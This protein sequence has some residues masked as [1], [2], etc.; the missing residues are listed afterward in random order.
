MGVDLGT[1]RIGVA[2]CDPDQRLAT[3][4]TV[5]VREGDPAADRRALVRLAA[6]EE[7]VGV[8]VG[9]PLSLDGSVGP[10]A[11]GALDEVAQ[12]ARALPGTAVDT[13]DE[14]FTTVAA[15]QALGGAAGGRR[16]RVAARQQVD[17]VAAAILLQS[18][19]DQRAAARSA[20]R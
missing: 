10:A 8:V 15:Y 5:L 6:E 9:L 13:V 20:E 12:L 7:V 3:S 2:L 17:A 1:A 11:R 4:L 19:L 14:R 18:W 16:R